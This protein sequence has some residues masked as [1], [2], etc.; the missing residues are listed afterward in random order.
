MQRLFLYRV[1]RFNKELFL[2]FVFIAGF[3]IVCNL[4][5]NEITPFYVWGM[6]SEKEVAPTEYPI[7]KITANDH[8]VDY[9]TGFLPENR[10]FLFAPL[11][12]YAA[13]KN[14]GADPT[15]LF[16]Q[17]KLKAKFLLIQPYAT[18]VLNSEKEVGEFPDWYK[19]Y[20]HQSTGTDIKKLKVEVLNATYNSNNS[21]KINST[22]TLINE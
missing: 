15:E 2:F 4:T 8:L 22:Y 10:L 9:T 12:Y 11:N 20:L 6:Y 19:R 13:M 21:I 17:E 7:F 14:S 3:T 16:L 18:Q 1:Y 5:G